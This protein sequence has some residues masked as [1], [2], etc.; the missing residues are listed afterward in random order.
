MPGSLVLLFQLWR[1]EVLVP[2]VL[3]QRIEALRVE[4]L[5]LVEGEERCSLTLAEVM[6]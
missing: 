4:C 6:W 5:E 2:S 3:I 1:F